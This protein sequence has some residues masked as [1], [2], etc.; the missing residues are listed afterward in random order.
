ML[1]IMQEIISSLNIFKTVQWKHVSIT[2]INFAGE[3]ST[4]GQFAAQTSE[5]E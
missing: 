1:F 5:L 2:A 3:R 4:G